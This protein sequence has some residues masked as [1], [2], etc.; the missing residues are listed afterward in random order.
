[1]FRLDLKTGE[2]IQISSAAALDPTS[3]TLLPGERNCCYFDGPVLRQGLGAERELYRVA[4]GWERTAGF[5]VTD[6]GTHAVFA[7]KQGNRSRL[8]SVSLAAKMPPA[9]VFETDGEISL[10]LPRPKR[11]QI[12]Y[13]KDGALWL[14]NMDGQQN[15]RLKTE[16][17]GEALW[18]PSGRTVVY[19]H[20]PEDTAQ[21]NTLRELTP[22]EN[23]DKLLA[24]TSQFAA[25]GENGDS[26]VFVGASRNKA[27]PT[28]LL[29]LRSARRE[30]TLCEHKASDP[31]TVQPIFSPDSQ[32]IFF[33]S[34]RH[35]KPA[36][37]RMKVE[38]L[39]EET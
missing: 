32:S 7:E 14:V 12:L 20:V 16:S 29:L 18:T 15:R 1:M 22:D 25:F 3:L 33:Q 28:V 26:S 36:I 8:R 21:L 4:D 2:S 34:D 38:K 27:S 19:L 30:F 24:K 37:Y 35:G 17:C 39:V 11:A 5:A 10:P 9:T 23:S 31:A 13:R 6:D